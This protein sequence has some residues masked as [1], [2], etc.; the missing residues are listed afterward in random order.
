LTSR[1]LASIRYTSE[2]V[3]ILRFD[4]CA[5]SQL[6]PLTTSL[7]GRFGYAIK[8]LPDGTALV[9][10]QDKITHVGTDGATYARGRFN[11]YALALDPDAESFWAHDVD[12][13]DIVRFDIA[14]GASL[15]AFNEMRMFHGSPNGWGPQPPY[16]DDAGT[17]DE[18][19]ATL[20]SV[21]PQHSLHATHADAVALGQRTMRGAS[22]SVSQQV[23]DDL[24]AEAVDESPPLA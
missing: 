3:S 8:T 12:T 9:A 20:A 22:M 1:V 13:G 23:A 17:Q 16:V 6:A 18:R 24:L 10:N 21:S 11:W 7:P 2:G 4:V 19:D 5:D 14:T 15:V